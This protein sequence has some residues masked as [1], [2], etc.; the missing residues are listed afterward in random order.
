M[1]FKLYCFKFQVSV[2]FRLSCLKL[3]FSLVPRGLSC[4]Y[5]GSGLVR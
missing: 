2:E 4:G 1:R 3:W 5:A